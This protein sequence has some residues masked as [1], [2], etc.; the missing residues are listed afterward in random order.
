MATQEISLDIPSDAGR[1]IYGALVSPTEFQATVKP[2]LFRT[3][4][5]DPFRL[6]ERGLG[7]HYPELVEVAEM[8]RRVQRLIERAK[9]AN[10]PDYAS[11]LYNRAKTGDGFAPQVVLWT[12]KE[13]VTVIDESTGLGAIVAP[14]ELHLIAIDGDTQAA[15]RHEG[16]RKYSDMP[17]NERI[18]VT[19]VHGIG[20]EAAQQIFHDANAKGVKVSTSLAIGFDNRDPLTRLSKRIERETPELKD[21]VNYQKR[22][23]GK[24]DSAVLTASALRTAVVCFAEGIA[25]VHKQT[26]GV[27]LQAGSETTVQEAALRWF[28]AVVKTLDGSL[29]ARS[30]TFATAPAVWA[31]L[32]ALGNKAVND[33]G[34]FQKPVDPTVLDLVFA[35]VLE[36]LKNVN[37][38]R[39]P[40]WLGAGAKTG[41]RG[42][43]LG[44]PKEAGH[45]VYRSLTSR[46]EPAFQNLRTAA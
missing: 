4:V 19:I 42:V 28:R 21:R 40:H 1:I 46:E 5:P 38:N 3:L 23:L 12:P 14:D 25:G 17:D 18:K 44:G 39:G 33:V 30:E 36:Q 43:T 11:Y 29:E 45:L 7:E 10:I 16:R 24:N 35:Q 9:K 20:L 6:E 26:D 8:R 22:Q 15:A 34:G 27:E 2:P 37:W 32:G 31:A 41:K 13:L